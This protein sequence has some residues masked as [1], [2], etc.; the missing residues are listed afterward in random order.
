MSIQCYIA[1]AEEASHIALLLET[2]ASH[3]TPD[4]SFRLGRIADSG[5]LPDHRSM[6]PKGLIDNENEVVIWSNMTEDRL[7]KIMSVTDELADLS[8][9]LILANDYRGAYSTEL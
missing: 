2:V 8:S 6:Y 9:S 3:R 7:R 5:N 4:E 1:F